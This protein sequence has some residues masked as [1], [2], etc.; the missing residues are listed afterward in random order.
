MT[1]FSPKLVLLNGP[2]HCGK[3]TAAAYV[4][5]KMNACHFKFSSPIKE[6]VKTIFGLSSAEVDYLESIKT[7]PSSLLVGKSYVDVQIS[8][9][10]SWA[11]QFFCQDI[12][13]HLALRRLRKIADATKENLFVSSD[14]GFACEAWPA[15]LE[16]FGV[17]NTL[18]VRI[19]RD[20]KTF[21]GD[22]RSYIELPGV[23]TVTICNNGDILE[24]QH[25]MVA[26]IEGWLLPRGG[27]NKC[28][29]GFCPMPSVRQGPPENGF[30]DIF[31]PI[32]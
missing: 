22:S 10:E 32:N 27:S 12:F 20:G 6:A 24:Y 13:G 7:T 23:E 5:Q 3:D 11:K 8:F 21:A 17:H 26:L 2:R 31:K 15:I 4:A 9:S 1:T 25:R 30:A 16:F 18:L 14:S 28:V 19:E 29:D